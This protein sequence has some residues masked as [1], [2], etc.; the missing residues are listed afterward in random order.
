[1][2]YL[3]LAFI[4]GGI[5]EALV[6]FAVHH[7]HRKPVKIEIVDPKLVVKPKPLTKDE[8]WS[9]LTN[10]EKRILHRWEPEMR[11][12]R[13]MHL[14]IDNLLL[15]NGQI[16]HL[17]AALNAREEVGGERVQRPHVTGQF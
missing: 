11:M 8:R 7:F 3:V 13:S 14:P 15:L 1:M 5:A 2:L 16:E 17:E 4:G 12:A 9:L 10:D 6:A